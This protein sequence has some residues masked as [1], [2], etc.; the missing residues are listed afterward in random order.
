MLI[1]Q[2][3]SNMEQQEKGTVLTE[4][5]IR[6]LEERFGSDKSIFVL[7]SKKKE[8]SGSVGLLSVERSPGLGELLGSTSD[9]ESPQDTSPEDSEDEERGRRGSKRVERG[10]VL[11]DSEL[12]ELMDRLGQTGT[13]LD[14]VFPR[15]KSQVCSLYLRHQPKSYNLDSYG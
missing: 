14:S 10:V 11:E 9:V 4:S 13:N 5:E 2:T 6:E 15:K 3:R 12:A 7:P 8:S 1:K